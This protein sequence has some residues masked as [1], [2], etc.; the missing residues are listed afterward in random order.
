VESVIQV[1]SRVQGEIYVRF[2]VESVR[3]LGQ[4][5][6]RD[7]RFAK[8]RMSGMVPVGVADDGTLVIAAAIDYAWWDNTAAEFAQRKELKGKRRTL[9][10]AGI[11]SD[12]AKQEFGKAG[13][14][15]RSGLR[16]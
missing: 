5:Q 3:M 13:W 10:I 2:L 14:M 6:G 9:L 8:I 1:A 11:A 16:P 4:Y 15:L 7:A 12:R